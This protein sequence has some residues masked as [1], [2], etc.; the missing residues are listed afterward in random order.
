[1]TTTKTGD[2]VLVHYLMRY[3]DGAEASSRANG[4]EPLEVTVGT[5][6]PRLPGLDRR[7]AGLAPGRDVFVAVPPGQAFRP[8]NPE[9]MARVARSRFPADLA[10]TVGSK[11]KLAGR[12][13]KTRAGRVVVATD[14]V[15]VVDLNHPR[16][17]QGVELE[18]ELVAILAPDA[19]PTG[20]P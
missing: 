13:G 10:L 4:G 11:V 3:E 17:G 9:K 15:V 14:R 12:S 18:V 6:H 19:L 8:S 7:L 16:A 20:T 2:R 5:P 1:M